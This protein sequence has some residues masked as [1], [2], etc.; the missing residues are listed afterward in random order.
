[1]RHLFA[2]LLPLLLAGCIQEAKWTWT[3]DVP[4]GDV[5]ADQVTADGKG[6]VSPSDVPG[7]EDTDAAAPKDIIDTLDP[8]DTVDILD[9]VDV[10]VPDCDGK[11]CGDDDC[12]GSCGTCDDSDPCNGQE[13]CD[14]GL[15]V[16]GTSPDCDDDN[17]CTDDACVEGEGCENTA[18]ADKAEFACDDG[19]PCTDDA[20]VSGA[21]ANPPKPL[22][23]LIIEN[24]LCEDDEGCEPL[25]DDDLCN[26][27]LVCDTEAETPTCM[28]DDDTIVTCMLTEGLAPE[29]NAALCAPGSG[30]CATGATNDGVVCDDGDFCTAGEECMAG[31]CGGGAAVDCEDSNPCTDDSC[32]P[33]IGCVNAP[34]TDDCDDEVDCTWS[35]QCSEG[36]CAGTLY[37]CDDPDQCETA[38]GATCNGDGTCTYPSAPMDGEP[39][40]DSSACTVGEACAGGAC[41]GGGPTNCDDGNVCTDDSCDEQLGCVSLDNAADCDDGD[42]CTTGDHCGAGSCVTTGTLACDDTN[43]CTDDECVEGIG[44]EYTPNT[45]PCEDGNSCTEGDH[46]EGGNCVAGDTFVCDQDH[47][48]VCL[49]LSCPTLAPDL[50]PTV[51]TPDGT[52]DL[53]APLPDTFLASR[54]IPLAQPGTPTGASTWRRTYEPVEIPLKNG[55]LDD[56]VVAYW[57]LDGGGATDSSGNGN[58]GTVAGATAA[59]GAFGDA[60]GGMAFEGTQGSHVDTGLSL[61]GASSFSATMWIKKSASTDGEFFGGGTSLGAFFYAMTYQ[62]NGVVY[63]GLHHDLGAGVDFTGATSVCDGAWHHVAAIYDSQE[64]RASVWVDG[65]LDGTSGPISLAA[66]FTPGSD[67]YIGGKNIAGG[68]GDYPFDGAIDDVVLFR[69]ALS[70]TEISAYYNSRSPYATDFVPGAQADLDD[71]RVTEVSEPGGEAHQIPFEVL[72]PRP[73]SDTPCPFDDTDPTTVPHIADR[74]DLCGV[75]AWWPMDGSGEDRSGNGLDINPVDTETYTTGRFGNP[76]GAAQMSFGQHFNHPGDPA[77]QLQTLTLEAFV[78]P[79]PENEQYDTGVLTKG[80]WPGTN[81]QMYV[82]KSGVL[83]CQCAGTDQEV[84]SCLDVEQGVAS[85][86]GWHHVACVF[87]ANVTSVYLDGVEVERCTFAAPPEDMYDNGLQVGGHSGRLDDILIHRVAKSP[88]YIYRRANPGVP[89]VRFLASTEVE[90]GA[91]DGFDWYEYT[92]NWGDGDAEGQQAVLTGL[93]GEECYGLLSSCLGYAGWWRFDEGSG[94]IAVD[95]CTWKRNGLLGA[96]DGMPEYISGLPVYVGGVDGTALQFDGT[97]DSVMVP[98][99]PSWQLNEEL[100]VQ[101]VVRRDSTNNFDTIAANTRSISDEDGCPQFQL[102]F[103]EESAGAQDPGDRLTFYGGDSNCSEGFR[104]WANADCATSG[105]WC[106]VSMVHKFGTAQESALYEDSSQLAGTWFGDALPEVS[107][108]ATTMLT[109]GNRQ[110]P[111]QGYFGLIDSMRI[112][113]R[114]LTPDEFL[115][116]PM[117]GWAFDPQVG[118]ASTCEGKQCGGDGCGGNCGECIDGFDC[119]EDGQCEWGGIDCGGITCPELSGYTVTCN[120]KA[121]CEYANETVT[122]WEQ[123]DTW[124]YIAPGSFLMGSTGEDGGSDETP[125]H[126]VAIGY[127]Y[128]ISKYEIV[129]EEYEACML[130]GG[131]CSA[132]STVDWDGNGWSTN[133]STGSNAP[134]P[135]RSDHPQNGLTWQ[136]AKDFCGWLAPG[137]RLPSESEWEFA[138][139]GPVHLKSPWGNNPAP[140]CS[141]NTAVFNEA[142][143]AGGYGCSQGGTWSVGSTVAGASWCGA[144]DMSGNLWEW[145]EDWYHNSYTNAPADGSAWVSPPDSNRVIRGGSFHDAAIYMRSAKRN[146]NTPGD[147]SASLGARCL[148]PLP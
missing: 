36:V 140:T 81:Y 10:C 136:Q 6:E 40:D 92:L 76:S 49:D 19:N 137:G 114:T 71:V 89:T 121:H 78:R 83:K 14:E 91:G 32:D 141:N 9:A 99:F 146:G 147:R 42:P 1:M 139:T 120:G 52:G 38:T 123:W 105:S 51:W 54:P 115:H 97:N 55:I 85:P 28:I 45:E 29:C 118:C 22:D 7:V 30:E 50:C 33:A 86:G 21:C 13:A 143:G 119:N 122:G 142:G 46:C 112:M 4:G 87:D 11:D 135:E 124:I 129:V 5:A 108:L 101:S 106:S 132:P 117:A 62:P 138:A 148:R 80:A 130:D 104:Y 56:S 74:E 113:N 131:T 88:E 82:T 15:C 128:F 26:G 116:L 125:K 61:Q 67:F 48:G 94:A 24:C 93:G 100:T 2:F 90:D 84:H 23:E 43:P 107:P 126:G 53:C 98:G 41:I 17:P 145:C 77:L 64:E 35:D 18:V 8:L 60:N 59:T 66:G 109:I 103:S 20:C 63:I 68:S 12:G 39:C 79:D 16:E 72:G 37:D 134:V 144:L 102:Y 27:T 25:E 127:G 133:M 70:P 111:G 69:R 34:N 65:N 44:C 96:T 31:A 75:V 58:H 110:T 73:H 95:S 57:K 3:G 47:D